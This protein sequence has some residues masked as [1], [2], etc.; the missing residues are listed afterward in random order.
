MRAHVTSEFHSIIENLAAKVTLLCDS[1]MFV[2]DVEDER[3]LTGKSCLAGSA[4]FWSGV[5]ENFLFRQ[6]F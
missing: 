5:L 2:L 3:G 6:F 1:A 4:I